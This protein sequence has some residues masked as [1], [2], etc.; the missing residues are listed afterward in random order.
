[1]PPPRVSPATPVEP[2]MPPVVAR[3][4]ACVAWL[5]SAHVAPASA[6][7][8][9]GCGIDPDAGGVDE[10]D[11]QGVVPGAEAGR[12]VAA[13]ADGQIQGVVPGEVDAGDD[14]GHLGYADDGCGPLVD[15]AVVDG[16]CGVVVRVAGRDDLPADL[17]AQAIEGCSVHFLT[18]NFVGVPDSG[19]CSALP[20]G[21][22]SGGL[23]AHA[24]SSSAFPASRASLTAARRTHPAG[25]RLR[26]HTRQPPALTG[27]RPRPSVG[28]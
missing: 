23:P 14:V 9:A 22:V 5:K 25:R 12:A 6:R 19:R 20:A 16:A 28:D 2:T 18:A 26:I 13:A 1:M 17:L 7:A 24:Y 3:P 4:K 15:H 21:M 27:R 11:D 10:V 8:V